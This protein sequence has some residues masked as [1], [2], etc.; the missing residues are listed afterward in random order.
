[1]SIECEDIIPNR[2]HVHHTQQPSDQSKHPVQVER[3]F[4]EVLFQPES[5]RVLGGVGTAQRP[6]EPV[7]QDFEP[8]Q[9]APDVGFWQELSQRK[10]DLWRAWTEDPGDGDGG[11]GSDLDWGQ[12]L[13][14]NPT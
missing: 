7:W 4:P 11:R 10:L 8:L 2:S 6:P 9:A 14:C 12:N 13:F 3:P 1:M 5:R